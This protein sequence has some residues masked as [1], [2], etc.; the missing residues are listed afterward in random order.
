ML[1][2][3]EFLASLQRE[4]DATKHLVAKL[5]AEH[6]AFRFSPG[7][8]STQEL[9]E[10]LAVQLAGGTSFFINGSW[11]AWETYE[12]Q[13]AGV[14]PATFGAAM[15][16]QVAEVH[17]LL[18]GVSDADFT[19]KIVKGP[20]GNETTISGGLLETVMKWAVGY[21]MQL[22]LQAKAAG[23]TTLASS[24]LWRGVDPAPKAAVG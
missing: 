13:V 17:R 23:L 16:R 18:Q 8:R 4:A 7:Q 10:H 2:K 12:K 14:T 6:L 11:D 5:S 9:I 3:A 20:M 19:Q 1:T 15:D 21:K 22:F 24:N